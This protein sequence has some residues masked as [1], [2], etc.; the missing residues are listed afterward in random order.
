MRQRTLKPE[1]WRDQLIARLPDPVRLFYA[2]LWMEADDEG[3]L[4]WDVAELGADLYPYQSVSRREANVQKWAAKLAE[5][6]RIVFYDC[7]HAHVPTVPKHRWQNSKA[8]TTTWRE[9]SGQCLGEPQPGPGSNAKTPQSR[10]EPGVADGSRGEPGVAAPGEGRGGEVREGEGEERGL[11]P[12]AAQGTARLVNL[13]LDRW[14]TWSKLTDGQID[15]LSDAL[16]YDTYESVAGWLEGLDGK[17]DP[18]T[19]VKETSHRLRKERHAR[20]DDRIAEHERLQA[21]E[22]ATAAS[23]MARIEQ[24]VGGEARSTFD[25]VFGEEAQA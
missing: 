22:A 19:V 10:A 23:T 3:W 7:G 12:L 18:I 20:A 14:P 24:R 5:L 4:R 25:E 6:R 11:N 16:Q 15:I 17:D 8:V 21:E 13:I 9:H 1:F 2:G